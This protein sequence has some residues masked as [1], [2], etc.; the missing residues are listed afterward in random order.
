[1]TYTKGPWT[2]NADEV[3]GNN[4]RDFIADIFNES[5]SWKANARLIAAAPDMLA[6]LELILEDPSYKNNV[7]RT[8][9]ARIIKKAKG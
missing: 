9:I 3:Y 6:V 5:E 2:L 4:G 1:M 8:S 7:G